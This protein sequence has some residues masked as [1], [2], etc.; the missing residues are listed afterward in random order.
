MT[1]LLEQHAQPAW[2]KLPLK[3]GLNR[4]LAAPNSLAQ[5]AVFSTQYYRSNATRPEYFE[6][7][8]PEAMGAIE[9]YLTAGHRLDQ[10][11]ADV[12]YELLRRILAEGREMDRESHIRFD[13]TELL[14]AIGRA[15]GGTT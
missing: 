12:L 4:N 9:L 2:P 15:R 3:Y 6:A 7:T 10:W 1:A 13:R 5:S 11:D 14:K 8:E